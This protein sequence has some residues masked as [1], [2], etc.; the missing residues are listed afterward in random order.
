MQW[1]GFVE[2]EW[3][4]RKGW[5]GCLMLFTVAWGSDA[6]AAKATGGD[7][8]DLFTFASGRT[9]RSVGVS[10]SSWFLCDR[11]YDG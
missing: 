10:F 7:R 2:K 4:Q 11:D 1:R 5:F 9:F 6:G 3:V 8:V